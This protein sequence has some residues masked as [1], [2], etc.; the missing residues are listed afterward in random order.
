MNK[1]TMTAAAICALLVLPACQSEKEALQ[2]AC[3]SPKHVDDSLPPAQRG[4]ALA[5]YIEAKVENDRVLALLGGSA[6]RMQKAKQLEAMAKTEGIETCE[7]A[8][9]WAT[10]SLPP[11]PARSAMP[12]LSA[13]PPLSAMT[14]LSATPP[15]PGSAAPPRRKA[16]WGALSV[17]Q[18]TEAVDKNIAAATDCYR[19]GVKRNK[20]LEGRLFVRFIIDSEGKVKEARHE[21]S[22][23]DDEQV[24]SCIVDA[25]LKMTFPKPAHGEVI[26]LYPLKLKLGT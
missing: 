19:E 8:K 16:V 9:L 14:S 1:R 12:A 5:S 6:P 22:T 24:L 26:V 17:E 7:L 11:R 21:A 3:D 18:V 20:K 25:F 15:A 10:P 23:L 13:A 2:L 4:Q